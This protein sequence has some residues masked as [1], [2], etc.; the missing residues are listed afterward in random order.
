MSRYARHEFRLHHACDF[1]IVRT[2]APEQRVDL[3]NEDLYHEQDEPVVTNW[4]VK[5]TILGSSFRAREN[6]PATSLLDSPNHL[7]VLFVSLAPYER[8]AINDSQA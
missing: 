8:Q 5:L 2:P 4:P 7:F 1:M 3:V 6:S